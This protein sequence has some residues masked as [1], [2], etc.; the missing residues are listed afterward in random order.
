MGNRIEN[1]LPSNLIVSHNLFKIFEAHFLYK[2]APFQFR[3]K[4]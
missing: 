3:Y 4:L 2:T 1:C